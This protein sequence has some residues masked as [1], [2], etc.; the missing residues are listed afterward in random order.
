MESWRE[1]R[2]S[3]KFENWSGLSSRLLP[4]AMAPKRNRKLKVNED[5]YEGGPGGYEDDYVQ[6]ESGPLAVG[7]EGR[8]EGSSGGEAHGRLVEQRSPR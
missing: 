8:K 4:L 2:E 6:G 5:D 3:A 7:D 1:E